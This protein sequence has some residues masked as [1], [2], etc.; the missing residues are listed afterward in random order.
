[1]NKVKYFQRG[2][3]SIADLNNAN[4]RDIKLKK[5]QTLNNF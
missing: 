1:M 2:G 3:V 4:L 5:A